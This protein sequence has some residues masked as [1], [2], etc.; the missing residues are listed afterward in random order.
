MPK[1][2]TKVKNQ[3]V[4]ERN[5][6]SAK[7]VNCILSMLLFLTQGHMLSGMDKITFIFSAYSCVNA[8]DMPCRS[9]HNEKRY[10]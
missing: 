7:S 6:R 2:T 4:V 8:S 9:I 1:Q 3:L 5:F 10:N